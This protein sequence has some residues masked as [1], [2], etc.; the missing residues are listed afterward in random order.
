MTSLWR[1]DEKGLLPMLDA[2]LDAERK[3]EDWIE[4]D[5]AMLDGDLIVIGR[6]VTAGSSGRIDLLGIKS[7]GSIQIIELKKNQTPREVIAQI[8]EYA[9]W[10]SKL[11]TADIHQ[12]AQTYS[13]EKNLSSL[14]ERFQ[15]A[16]GK[17]L[18]ELL[19]SS[20]GML[21]VASELDRRSKKIIEYLSEIHGVLINTA[22]FRVFSDGD[23]RYLTA[24]WLMDQDEVVERTEVRTK[25]PWSGNWYVNVGDDR[26]RS[27]ADMMKYGFIAAGGG[28]FYSGKLFQLSRG[29]PIYAYQKQL[30]YVGFGIV[31]GE[32]I[33]AR[34]HSID[35]TP[36]LS[37]PLSQKNLAHDK[38][39]EE[40]GEYVVPIAWKKAV[41]LAEAKTFVGAFANQNIVCRLRDQATL[42]F[43]RKEFGAVD[44]SLK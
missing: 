22:F 42:D 41:P 5:P 14:T 9:S 26:S 44:G 27:W 21:L 2:Q 32:A 34:D 19:N 3:L 20:H 39:D 24:D 28:R 7:D 38:D 31:D 15:E 13:G 23:R 4:N 30:G 35:G 25:A 11:G 12:I 37:L 40:K 1:I 10:V 6:Q 18:P 43:L 36:L 16:F 17:P 29:D 33:L 8:L